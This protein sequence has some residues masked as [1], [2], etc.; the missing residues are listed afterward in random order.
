MMERSISTE[1]LEQV[2]RKPDTAVA[3]GPKWIFAKEF[4]Y[5]GDNLIAAVVVERE[6]KKL[7]VV[8]TVMV[9]FKR[10]V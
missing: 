6:D 4:Q 5:R 7:W 1:E 3:Q 2:L 8:I 10:N 9:Q